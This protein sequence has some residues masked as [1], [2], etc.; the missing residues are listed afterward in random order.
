MVACILTP[1]RILASPTIPPTEHHT[2]Q[3]VPQAEA[4]YEEGGTDKDLPD[5]NAEV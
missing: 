3:K 4:D 5:P 1:R 2:K